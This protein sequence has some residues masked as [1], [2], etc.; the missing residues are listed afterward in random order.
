[1]LTFIMQSRRRDEAAAAIVNTQLLTR[2][3][4]G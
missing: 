2:V 1:M 3:R 4:L